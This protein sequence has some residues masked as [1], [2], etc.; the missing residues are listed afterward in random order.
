MTDRPDP[1]ASSSDIVDDRGGVV[2][3]PL[4]VS[5]NMAAYR[6]GCEA[7]TRA[8]TAA[9]R[10]R[11]E[12]EGRYRREVSAVRE[13]A[14]A[15]VA[16]REA[17]ARKADQ[18]TTLVTETDDAAAE[19]WRKLASFTDRRR[20]GITPA[21]DPAAAP[22]T[23]AEVRALLATARKN[24][25]AAQRGELPLPP[26]PH[27]VPIAA[28]FGAIGGVLGAAGGVLLLAAAHNASDGASAAFHA[29]ALVVVFVGL[30]AGVPVAAG[31]LTVRHRV[32]PKPAHLLAAVIGAV[33]GL[34]AVATPWTL[35]G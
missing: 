15:A 33:V 30:F 24:I 19:I 25:G 8:V 16:R 13:T 10:A 26:P 14:R 5:T 2:D 23:S 12:A 22:R 31:W 9:H 20:L 21:P 35:I 1:D 34:C 3:A 17:A 4:P 29:L 6:T 27:A 18:A 11:T 28:G 32:G 7:Y